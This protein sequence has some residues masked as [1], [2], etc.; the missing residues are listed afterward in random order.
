VSLGVALGPI[1]LERAVAELREAIR[2]DPESAAAH[3]NLAIVLNE[4]GKLAEVVAEFR[5]AIRVEPTSTTAHEGLGA[6]LYRQ[7]K[8]DE[9]IAEMR[10]ALR[11]R[12][13][14]DKVHNNLAWAF[15]MTPGRPRR[16]LEEALVHARTAV[17]LKPDQGGYFGTLALAE[18]RAG[19][20]T[21]S[22]TAGKRAAALT[23]GGS[24]EAGFILAM[25]CWQKGAKD[26][27]RKWFDKAVAWAGP[28]AHRDPDLRRL[29]L[30]SAK[31]LGRPG[32]DESEAGRAGPGAAG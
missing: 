29:W 15:L 31:L 12:P 21:E 16:D 23:K 28:K 25:S 14:H 32:P 18:Y 7:G 5:E 24:A 10:E 8:P 20:W 19:H 27:A 3:I 6:G 22:I 1:Q 2:L 9:A 4:Q 30:E 26:E 17:E 11:L 13:D